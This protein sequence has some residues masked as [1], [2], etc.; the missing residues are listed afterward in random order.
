MFIITKKIP[1][2]RLTA[3]LFLFLLTLGLFGAGL[4]LSHDIRAASVSLPSQPDPTGIRSNQDRIDYLEGFGWITGED[5]AAV[6]EILLPESFGKDYRDYLN[7]QSEQGFDLQ[8]YAGKTVKR[9]TYQIKNYPGLR[10]NI[11]AS[12]LVYQNTVIGGEVFCS[13][14]DGFTQS[15][16]YPAE[17]GRM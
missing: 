12:M 2:R 10:E 3:A 1:R 5:P 8:A 13:E 7:L 14:G 9:Y 16:V 11:W 6:E 4:E 15:L 17:S